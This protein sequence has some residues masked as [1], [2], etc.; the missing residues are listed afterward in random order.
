MAL[1]RK[2][3]KN[4]GDIPERFISLFLH[5]GELMVF[6]MHSPLHTPLFGYAAVISQQLLES[7]VQVHYSGICTRDMERW[8]MVA[9]PKERHIKPN[10]FVDSPRRGWGRCILSSAP[11]LF[12]TRKFRHFSCH[13]VNESRKSTSGT[14]LRIWLMANSPADASRSSLRVRC[15]CTI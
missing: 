10:G 2:E 1:N 6:Y 12:S 11:T 7:L 15:L 8:I 9:S 4:K 14:Q 13:N 5:T 3:T